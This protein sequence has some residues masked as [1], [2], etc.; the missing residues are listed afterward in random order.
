MSLPRLVA[1]TIRRHGLFDADDRVLIALSGGADSVALA[2]LLRHAAARASWGVAGLVH[3]NHGLRGAASD[4]DESFCRALAARFGWPIEV[5]RAD[6]AGRARARRCSL[7]TAAREARYEAFTAAAARLG[8]TAVATGHTMDDQAETVLLRLLRGTGLRG[9]SSI[10]IRRGLFRRPLL[11]CR[12]A[13]LREYLAELGEPFREDESNRDESIAR[14]RVRHQLLPVVESLSPGG[15]EAIARSAALAADDEAY[16]T[17]AARSAAETVVVEAP[18]PGAR[19]Q[20]AGDD[21]PRA[22]E[23]EHPR[24]HP[25]GAERPEPGA[26]GPISLNAPTL[27]SLPAPLARRVVRDVVLRAWPDRSWS[28]RHIDAVRRLAASDKRSG[29]LDLPGVT[30]RKEGRVL[31]LRTAAPRAAASR[32]R[33]AA[34]ADTAA[35]AAAHELPVPGAVRVPE[36]GLTLTASIASDGSAL[37]RAA[38]AHGMAAVLQAGTFA[39][40]LAV[41]RRRPGDRL[42]P[43]GAPGRRKLQDVLVDRKIARAERDRI[44]I[45]TDAAGRIVWVSGVAVAHECRVTSARAG[46][47]ILEIRAT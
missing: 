9:L 22:A 20:V 38:A 45:V 37:E 39:P 6:V 8:A 30:A 24:F 23:S 41:R 14:N 43:L 2:W 17:E 32:R 33:E 11:E 29:G 35:R 36:L 42:R 7:E 13:A 31:E 16:L 18:G 25:A 46:M 3:V 5:E 44:P 15:V 47:V 12:R 27:A 1:R 26:E 21:A 4:E 10:R 34:K 28:G 40:P 19:G